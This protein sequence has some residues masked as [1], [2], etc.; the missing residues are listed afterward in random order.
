MEGA[1]EAKEKHG[2][3]ESLFLWVWCEI[4]PKNSAREANCRQENLMKKH[5]KL[6]LNR[7]FSRSYCGN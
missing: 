2:I 6:A 5:Q 4:I 3:L 7:T 1:L